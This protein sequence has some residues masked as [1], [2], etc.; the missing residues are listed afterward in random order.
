MDQVWDHS[1]NFLAVT[2][3]AD[4][5]RENAPYITTKIWLTSTDQKQITVLSLLEVPLTKNLA[6]LIDHILYYT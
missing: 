5:F 1:E 3:E 2:N 6:K 4:K